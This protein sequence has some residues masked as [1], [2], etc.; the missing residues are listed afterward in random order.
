METCFNCGRQ[1][2][3]LREGACSDCYDAL[4]EACQSIATTTPWQAIAARHTFGVELPE[5]PEQPT[6]PALEASLEALTE[7]VGQPIPEPD[8]AVE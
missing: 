6:R 7:L 2:N 8:T 4:A 5:Y 1:S 3:R